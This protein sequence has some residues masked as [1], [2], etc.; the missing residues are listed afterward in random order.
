VAGRISTAHRTRD[1]TPTVFAATVRRGVTVSPPISPRRTASRAI[2]PPPY[3]KGFAAAFLLAVTSYGGGTRVQ[4]LT[5]RSPTANSGA[6]DCSRGPGV[7]DWPL[8]VP[9]TLC[10]EFTTGFWACAVVANRTARVLKMAV[11]TVFMA[12]A[13]VFRLADCFHGAVPANHHM[14]A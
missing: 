1:R 6:G 12:D 7:T 14:R 4:I 3:G 2:K 11:R 9:A 5:A 8:S 13:L 10:P